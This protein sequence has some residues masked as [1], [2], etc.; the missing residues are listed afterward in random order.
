MARPTILI[1]W[2]LSNLEQTRNEIK[3]DLSA[4]V[5]TRD[6]E[7]EIE[8]WTDKEMTIRE[9][10]SQQ[11]KHSIDDDENGNEYANDA[12]QD[13]NVRDEKPI[14]EKNVTERQYST[15][16]HERS[17]KQNDESRWIEFKLRKN[18]VHCSEKELSKCDQETCNNKVISNGHNKRPRVQTSKG[19]YEKT[20][21]ELEA[22]SLLNVL[23]IELEEEPQAQRSMLHC[24]GVLD[25]L[26]LTRVHFQCGLLLAMFARFLDL[27]NLVHQ[28]I[29]S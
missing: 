11:R 12:S 2:T 28:A 8:R 3:F 18:T 26:R 23:N 16:E 7:Q 24:K 9:Q 15:K 4:C 27:K 13:Q 21:F 25:L 5:N 1:K 14:D 22:Q 20:Q 17:T 10:L 29:S 6:S 19:A